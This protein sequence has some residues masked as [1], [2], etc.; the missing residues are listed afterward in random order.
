[1]SIV[2]LSGSNCLRQ[3]LV[4][5]ILSGRPMRVSGI[6]CKDMDRGLNDSEMNLLKLVEKVTNGSD[7]YVDERGTR[8][9]FKPGL[10]Y[11]GHVDHDCGLTRSIVYSLELLLMLSPFCK[12]PIEARLTGVTND[13]IDPSVDA[14]KHSA[15]AVMKPFFGYVDPEDLAIEVVSRGLP[16]DGGGCVTLKCP[17][18]RI[19]RPV[20]CLSAGKVKRVRGIAFATRVSPQIANRMVA[21][22]KG[23][24]LKYIPDIYIYTDH[25]K[26]AKSGKSRGFGLCLWA[27]TTT[28][29]FYTG[30]AVSHPSGSGKETEAVAEDIAVEATHALLNDIY[31]GGAVDTQNQGLCALLMAFGQRDLSKAE[32]GPLT[33]FT[34]QMLRH[35]KTFVDLTFKL[36]T[37]SSAER[38]EDIDDQL[39][40][41]SKKVVATCIGIGFSNLNK[42][43]S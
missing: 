29:I 10:P 32:F 20:Q 38:N 7:I 22:A 16:P 42:T 8:L 36:D 26:G 28:G 12:H 30:D 25:L 15:P 14:I 43:V 2:D 13:R 6:R 39:K 4:L 18:R 37:K 31:R 23:I 41:G 1:M 27:E 21:E 17:I 5:S 40:L 35:I 3:R 11:G 33:P 24:L 9:M 19:L 34:I